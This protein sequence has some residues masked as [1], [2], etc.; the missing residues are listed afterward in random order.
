MRENIIKCD[1]CC[2]E[3][4]ET[5]VGLISNIDGKDFCSKEC[6]SEYIRDLNRDIKFLKSLKQTPNLK[7]CPKCEGTGEV[8]TK[9]NT[10]IKCRCCNGVGSIAN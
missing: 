10:F 1:E 2:R 7:R 3:V 4:S 5:N 8:V 9:F 6:L